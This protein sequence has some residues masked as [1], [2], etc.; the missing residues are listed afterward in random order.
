[1]A[2]RAG[3]ALGSVVLTFAVIEVGLRLGDYRFSP[4]ML[5]PR[6]TP[7]DFR[8]F[9][10]DTDPYAVF[11]ADL[12]W[13]PNPEVWADMD[14]H[15]Y[16]GRAQARPGEA[17]VVAIGD[18]NTIGAPGHGE[19]WTA[20]LQDLLDHN[21]TGRPVRV[22]NAGCFG[23][24]S[25]QGLRRF[26][27]VLALRPTVVF[28]SFG[29]NDAH[30]VTSPDADYAARAAW[31]RRWS[32]LRLAAPVAHRIWSLL[33]A[34]EQA[35]RYRPR[36]SLDEHRRHLEQFVDAARAHGITPVLLTRPYVGTPDNQANWMAWA[37]RYRKLS[38]E[39]A[40]EKGA[41]CVDVYHAF[42]AMPQLFQDESHFNRMGRHRM[43]ALLLKELKELGLAQTDYAYEPSLEPG[44]VP[45]EQ[46]ELGP[47][48]WAAEP[49]SGTER[50]RWTRRTAVAFLER[51]H[52]EDRLEVALSLLS[53][54]GQTAGRIEVNGR[55]LARIEGG[56]GPW[57]RS[58]DVASIAERQLVVRFVIEDPYTPRSLDPQAQDARTLGVFVHSVRLRG[59]GPAD[60]R[61]AV[62]AG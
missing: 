61:S 24:A 23:W 5:V 48:W 26:E 6:E 34:R 7:G 10:L 31:L 17:L 42:A 35:R 41:A 51:R 56:N 18:S 13:R 28:F 43:A 21:A 15:G 14:E 53:P 55:P 33:D 8:A 47:G 16:R 29:A 22:L 50:G 30:R 1:M 59:G 9:H 40:A 27:Q 25:L 46:P 12:F 49:W 11:D 4:I 45:D 38:R 60:R 20:D 2:G 39:V 54:R 19:H 58:L 36:V 62:P 37:G 44:R 32:G 3:L 52:G 57:H